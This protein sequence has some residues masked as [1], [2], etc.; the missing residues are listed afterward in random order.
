MGWPG[1]CRVSRKL[2]G[3]LSGG[4]LR[5][6]HPLLSG[7]RENADTCCARVF[8][9]STETMTPPI[10]DPV[11]RPLKQPAGARL[12]IGCYIWSRAS[13][14][15]RSSHSSPCAAGAATLETAPRT[16][17]PRRTRRRQRTV[18]HPRPTHVLR[19]HLTQQWSRSQA[20]GPP[21][22]LDTVVVSNLH[23][24]PHRTVHAFQ[25]IPAV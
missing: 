12:I 14:A 1:C 21:N 3:L 9:V 8:L 20:C 17:F 19:S 13:V 6:A 15:A 25:L 23:Q 4:T 24:L 16:T 2:S 11:A 5:T 18:R 22:Q 7:V 10:S